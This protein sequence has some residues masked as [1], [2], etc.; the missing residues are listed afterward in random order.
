LKW[1]SRPAW[2]QRVVTSSALKVERLP[3]PHTTWW[4]RS[5]RGAGTVGTL[6]VR[7]E[8]STCSGGVD[9][10]EAEAAGG[11]LGAGEG[12]AAEEGEASRST[13]K[14]PSPVLDLSSGCGGAA[15]TERGCSTDGGLAGRFPDEGASPDQ[16]ASAAAASVANVSSRF[17]AGV[18][19][20]SRAAVG[21]AIGGVWVA[22]SMAPG[23]GGVA[24]APGLAASASMRCSDKMR[25][26]ASSS[27]SSESFLPS[28]RLDQ[29]VTR[30]RDVSSSSWGIG[31]DAIV[32][33]ASVR[34][35]S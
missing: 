26:R 31:C 20:V 14:V 3:S 33:S 17:G 34:R 30:R 6:T 29:E 16:G 7:G 24:W 5:V 25:P 9:A 10:A 13:L 12:L 11:N 32:S 1:L 28:W 23:K 35:W 22:W 2:S 4:R 18:D 15:S 21:V 8:R 19:A 27:S